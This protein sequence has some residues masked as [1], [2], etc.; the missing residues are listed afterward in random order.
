MKSRIKFAVFAAI[1]SVSTI[2]SINAQTPTA[3]PVSAGKTYGSD[4]EIKR[5]AS[6]APQFPSPVTFTDITAQTLINFKHN[7]S[8]TSLKY[9]PETMSAGA[10]MIRF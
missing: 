7:A 5:P 8:P 10:A 6:A 3:S 9:L 4:V 2:F 1:F